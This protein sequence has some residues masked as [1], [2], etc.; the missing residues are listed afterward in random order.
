M[1]QKAG[2]PYRKNVV[3]PHLPDKTSKP[4]VAE[5]C[6]EQ[7]LFVNKAKIKYSETHQR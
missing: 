4:G 7:G 2:I 6:K 1:I 3:L 5:Y